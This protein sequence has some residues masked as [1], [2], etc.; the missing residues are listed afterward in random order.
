M[1]RLLKDGETVQIGDQ[2]LIG[3]MWEKIEYVGYPYSSTGH[4]LMRRWEEKWDIAN[5]KNIEYA[6][7]LIDHQLSLP[8]NKR[9]WSIIEMARDALKYQS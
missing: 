9:D 1:W 4:V 8:P 5:D 7:E 2:A 3:P 6:I